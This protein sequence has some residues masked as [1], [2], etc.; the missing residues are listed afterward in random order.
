MKKRVIGLNAK[1]M[2]RVDAQRKLREDRRGRILAHAICFVFLSALIFMGYGLHRVGAP[3]WA[4]FTVSQVAA[5]NYHYMA[6]SADG[7]PNTVWINGDTWSVVQV[8]RFDKD[9][10]AAE[11]VC[12]KKTIAYLSDENPTSLRDNLW[13]E[14]FHAGG[15]CSHGTDAWWNNPEKA[16]DRNDHPGIYNLGHF[17]G[18]FSM[19]NPDFMEWA[20]GYK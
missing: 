8:S 20:S 2:A 7:V 4:N 3:T 9:A 11:T 12:E 10:E 6:R 19:A 18:Q 16:K 13:H 15:I 14:I 17:M 1:V 5:D